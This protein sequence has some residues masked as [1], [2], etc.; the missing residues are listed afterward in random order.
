[1]SATVNLW[2]DVLIKPAWE[3]DEIRAHY[4]EA[5]HVKN[6]DELKNERLREC[7]K[8]TGITRRVEIGSF[9]TVGPKTGLGSSSSFVVGLLKALFAIQNQPIDKEDLARAACEIEVDVLKKPMGKQD[10]YAAAFGGMNCFTFEPDGSVKVEHLS[11]PRGKRDE[12]DKRLLLFYTGVSRES[13]SVLVDQEKRTQQDDK[14]MLE[15]LHLVKELGIESKKALNAG[16]LEL[17]GGLMHKHWEIKKKRSTNMTNETI[18]RWYDFAIA[19][20]AIG[21]KLVG[22]GGGGFLMFLARDAEKLR[23]A[24][25]QEGLEE[26]KFTFDPE[27]SRVVEDDSNHSVAVV[28]VN[29]GHFVKELKWP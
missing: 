19:N 9:A 22:A 2:I 15:N 20:G 21:G 14:E 7:L 13:S 24:M 12:L 16:D 11:M 8:Y 6:V 3:K 28:G 18:S 10:Q 26:I 29:S 23:L 4:S 25:K 17:F 5:E 1:M 27:G